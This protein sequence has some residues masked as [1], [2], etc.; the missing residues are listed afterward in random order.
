MSEKQEDKGRNERRI[1]R[2]IKK[3]RNGSNGKEGTKKGNIN[4]QKVGGGGTEVS[5]LALDI[6]M[7]CT[8]LATFFLE[9]VDQRNLY[10]TCESLHVF[11]TDDRL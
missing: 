7:C 5:R 11:H 4:K 1:R 9:H 8:N 2:K 10:R 6:K 3:G